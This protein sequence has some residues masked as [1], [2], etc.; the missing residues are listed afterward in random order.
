MVADDKAAAGGD[1]LEPGSQSPVKSPDV[2][3]EPGP[4]FVV[5][6]DLQ[7]V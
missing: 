4:P 6:M 1:P 7:S 2:W 3:D 5:I